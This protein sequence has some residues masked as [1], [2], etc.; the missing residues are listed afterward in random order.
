MSIRNHI[1]ENMQSMANVLATDPETKDRYGKAAKGGKEWFC[2]SRWIAEDISRWND[3][4]AMAY[5]DELAA[6]LASTDIA[7]VL[8]YETNP[9]V[10]AYLKE[11]LIAAVERETSNERLRRR[12]R[13]L[14]N[15]LE[16][17]PVYHGSTTRRLAAQYGGGCGMICRIYSAMKG[18]ADY[19]R[20][21][22]PGADYWTH[23]DCKLYLE[24]Y[25][26]YDAPTCGLRRVQ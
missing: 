16:R 1:Y 4:E 11:K 17:K 20:G 3:A 6:W 25:N 7:Y 9:K 13:I 2:F 18:Y 22:P 15:G 21:N 24:W 10:V 5:R 26:K 23:P 14:G 12:A 19:L 8:Q